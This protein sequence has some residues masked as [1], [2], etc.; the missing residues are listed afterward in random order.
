MMDPYFPRLISVSKAPLFPLE[1]CIDFSEAPRASWVETLCT[2]AAYLNAT[3]F[4]VQVYYDLL[5]GRD[6][7]PVSPLT[8]TYTSY[9]K[10]VRFLRERL[11]DKDEQLKLSDNTV[12]V[13]LI[14][15]CHAHRLGQYGI[16]RNHMVGLRKIVDMR[17]GITALKTRAK[18][19][20]EIFR[21]DLG[22]ALH[23]GFNPIFFSD[24]CVEE[25]I[26]YPTRFSF[27]IP[28]EFRFNEAQLVNSHDLGITDVELGKVWDTMQAFCSLINYAAKSERKMPQQL[29]LD[30]MASGMYRLISMKFPID[31]LDEAVRL[32]LSAFC[33]HIFLQWSNARLPHRHLP[34]MYKEC[35]AERLRS[36]MGPSGLMPWFV[37]VGAMAVFPKG[38]TWLEPWLRW[39]TGMSDSGSWGEV[40][41]RLRTLLWIDFVHDRYG[42]DIYNSVHRP[43]TFDRGD[44]YTAQGYLQV[45]SSLS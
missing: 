43:N 33:S 18:L 14:L 23:T 42:A 38:D 13:V 17:G 39:A 12:M 44:N 3:V 10:T 26:P 2:D 28:P 5:A 15:A 32:G 8:P 36:G 34:T 41:A 7:E 1:S 9:S 30:T 25:F 27:S 19:L 24:P 37:M 11:G 35:L 16:A 45:E 40:R 4:S 22:M 6:L 29:F 20:I 31:S 21:C